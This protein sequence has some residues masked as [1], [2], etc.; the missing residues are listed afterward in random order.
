MLD[1]GY[2]EALR[3]TRKHTLNQFGWQATNTTR[4]LRPAVGKL[5]LY[6]KLA[7]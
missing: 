7:G 1:R 6:C 5:T 2:I 3:T 4:R